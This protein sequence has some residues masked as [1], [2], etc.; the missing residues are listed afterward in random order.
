MLN[1]IVANM[2]TETLKQSQSLAND[3]QSRQEELQTPIRNCKKRPA[4]PPT[5]TR[6]SNARIAKSNK[7]V[8]PPRKRRIASLDFEIKSEFPVNM[9]HELVDPLNSL[10]SSDQLPRTLGN[11]RPNK[12]SLLRLFYSAGTDLPR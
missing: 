2:R 5:R 12:P 11:S 10:P 1:T 7:P 8:R 4:S 6:K 9:S 3:F